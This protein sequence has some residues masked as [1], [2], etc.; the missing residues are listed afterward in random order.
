MSIGVVTKNTL[1]KIEKMGRMK[2]VG[3]ISSWAIQ[4]QMSQF[5]SS[6]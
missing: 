6:Y 1:G 2:Q 4:G 3:T 5:E